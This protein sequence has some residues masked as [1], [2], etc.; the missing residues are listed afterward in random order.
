MTGPDGK[1]KVKVVDR[2]KKTGAGVVV[3][4]LS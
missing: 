2:E 4:E 1:T 3:V